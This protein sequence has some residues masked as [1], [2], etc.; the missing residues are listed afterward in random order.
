[1]N[2]WRSPWV[3][4]VAGALSIFACNHRDE[5]GRQEVLRSTSTSGQWRAVVLEVNCHATARPFT[6]A[7]LERADG[8]PR[9]IRRRTVYASNYLQNVTLDWI[10]PDTLLL[11][12]GDV[13]RRART[14]QTFSGVTV[15]YRFPQLDRVDSAQIAPVEYTRGRLRFAAQFVRQRSTTPFSGEL[16]DL[17]KGPGLWRYESQL[18]DAW[19]QLPTIRSTVD[20]TIASSRG[21]DGV[22]GNGDDIVVVTKHWAGTR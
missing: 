13:E 5:C 21:P 1:M 9:A 18:L 15:L 10:G 4:P 11:H 17:P 7:A 19:M 8:G 16:E 12:T 14:E 2:F 6:E 22:A 20:S 3:L